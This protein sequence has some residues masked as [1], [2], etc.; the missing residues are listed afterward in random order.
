MPPKGCEPSL[1]DIRLLGTR[2]SITNLGSSQRNSAR[3]FRMIV[4]RHLIQT[5][6]FVGQ[7][8]KALSEFFV[9]INQPSPVNKILVIP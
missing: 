1:S 8:L 2:Q 3:R 4:R 6:R 9:N 5:F 7:R